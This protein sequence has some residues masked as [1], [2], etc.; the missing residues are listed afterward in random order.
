MLE[1][2]EMAMVGATLLT[3]S[4]KVVV[5][6]PP[7]PSL[8]VIVTVWPWPGPSVVPKDQLHVPLLVPVFEIVPT[9]AVIVTAVLSTSEYVPLLAAVEPSLTVTLALSAAT[10]GASLT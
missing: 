2:P 1:G 8:A 4:A 7:L 3:V 5:V 10:T 6:T 9:D